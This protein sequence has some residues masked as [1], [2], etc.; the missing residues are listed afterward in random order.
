MP[1]DN[2]QKPPFLHLS[3]CLPDAQAV[4]PQ[5]GVLAVSPTTAQ[6]QV[7]TLLPQPPCFKGSIHTHRAKYERNAAGLHR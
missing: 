3:S 5:G 1:N 4:M 2:K 7:Q 6:W